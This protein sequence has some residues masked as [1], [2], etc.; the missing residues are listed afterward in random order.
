[1]SILKYIKNNFF[2]IFFLCFFLFPILLSAKNIDLPADKIAGFDPSLISNINNYEGGSTYNI[3]TIYAGEDILTEAEDNGSRNLFSSSQ[4]DSSLDSNKLLALTTKLK[5][6][7]ASDIDISKYTTQNMYAINTDNASEFIYDPTPD[8]AGS[9]DEVVVA[10]ATK[11]GKFLGLKKPIPKEVNGRSREENIA[12]RGQD[13]YGLFN[14]TDNLQG[15]EIGT[16]IATKNNVN[17]KIQEKIDA[18][19]QLADAEAKLKAAEDILAKDPNNIAAKESVAAARLARDKAAAGATLADSNLKNAKQQAADSSPDKNPVKCDSWL[20]LVDRGCIMDRIARIANLVLKIVSFI[21]YIVGTLFDYSLELSIN[22]AQFL[23]ELGVVEIAWSFIRDILNMTFIFILLWTSVQ[24]LLGNDAKYNAKKVL[25]NVVIVAI[26]MNF[27]L[28]GA[29]LMVDGSNIVT[30]KIYEAM[31]SGG[32]KGGPSASISQRVMT[33]VGMTTLYNIT[34]V[35]STSNTVGDN[36]CKDTSS[37]IILISVMGS[38]FLIILCLALVLAGI[39]FLIRLVNIIILFIKSPLFV[40]GFVLPGSETMKGL[41]NKWWKEMMHVLTFPIMYMFWM[42][43]AVL[44]FT[45]LG[46]ANTQSSTGGLL[47]LIC[48]SAKGD[49]FKIESSISIVAVFAIVIIFMMKTIEYGF[50]NATGGGDGAWG[51]NISKNV[52]DKF[53]KYQ[54][55]MTKG[56]ANKVGGASVGAAKGTL[57]FAATTTG[58]AGGSVI[59]GAK[60]KIQGGNWWDGTKDGFSNPGISTKEALR[61]MARSVAAGTANSGLA[62]A[63]G[64]TG[65]AARL[66]ARYDDPKNV[67]G[68]TKKEMDKE[69]T[70]KA[71]EDEKLRYEAIDKKYKIDSQKDWLRRHSGKNINDYKEYMEKILTKRT[72]ALLGKNVS[73]LTNKN[74]DKH[75]DELKKKAIEEVEDSAGNITGYKLNEHAMHTEM[76]SII[77][78]HTKGGG[79]KDIT[80]NKTKFTTFRNIKAKARIKAI[81]DK[82]K[83]GGKETKSKNDDEEGTKRYKSD[84]EKLDEYIG[85]IPDVTTIETAISTLTPTSLPPGSYD[86]KTLREVNMSIVKYNQEARKA[87]PRADKLM[88]LEN[89]I[90]DAKQAYIDHIEAKKNELIKKKADYDAHLARIEEKNKK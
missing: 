14:L 38:I 5:N 77:D 17:S 3:K 58:R 36:A 63:L 33:A 54:T 50:K 8:K 4:N 90:K 32:V 2:G 60:S 46:E 83:E 66:A 79:S 87:S 76:S 48:N 51:N 34:D 11:D 53:N 45:K 64:I 86:G 13:S 67:E 18:D 39:L 15:V 30:L 22:S 29:K 72:D 19:N 68:K 44:V 73:E 49:G 71:A 31:K 65:G 28:F 47:G 70:L 75:I 55:A 74:G 84:I 24:I 21:T 26:L 69:R 41:K 42:F 52:T 88:G 89:K 6:S 85:K 82:V 9:G 10:A 16:S 61:D 78:Y 56:L 43:I 1:M 23:G 25:I 62:N 7:G 37:A 27:S 57:K 59:G 81:S 40:W 20:S 80:D 12:A 35:F